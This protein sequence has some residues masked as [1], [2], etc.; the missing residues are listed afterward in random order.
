MSNSPEVTS[1]LSTSVAP[2]SLRG[3]MLVALSGALFGCMGFFG[4][5]I[6]RL[7]FSVE[8]ML[9]WRFLVATIWIAPSVIRE[10]QQYRIHTAK[11]RHPSHYFKI[12]MFSALSY[13]GASAFYF[14][15][16]FYIGT[17][18]AMVLF[19]A[20]PIVVALFAWLFDG[21][22]FTKPAMLSLMALV[23]GLMLLKGQGEFALNTTGIGFAAMAA[24]CFA[25]YVYGSQHTSKQWSANQLT[26]FVCLGNTLLFLLWSGYTASFKVPNTM[27]A[28]VYCLAIGIIA[29]ALPI[30]LLLYGLKS[31][32]SVKASILS[33]FEPVVTLVLG[34]ILL[35]E[36]VSVMQLVGI[37]M[38]LLSTMVI[39]FEGV[40]A[41]TNNE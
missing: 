3:S 18:L 26:L 8:G 33:S 41:S 32:S 6:L 2:S 10:S 12:F 4:T 16:T 35:H 30:Q 28:W 20:F 34:V 25:A 13:S 5:K 22:R 39:Q 21:W 40:P 23:T 29:T 19:Y 37:G 14:L 27:D 17:G 11:T 31:V 9:F 36:V 1:T 7:G 24:A 15:S 38:I